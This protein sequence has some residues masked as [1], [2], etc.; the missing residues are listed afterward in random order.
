[1]IVIGMKKM[2][3]I[4]KMINYL[5]LG[6]LF[7]TH[8]VFLILPGKLVEPFICICR[9]VLY[10]GILTVLYVF[11]DENDCPVSKVRRDGLVVGVGTIIYVFCILMTGILVGFGKNI[12]ASSL[13]SIIISVWRYATVAVMSEVL[14]H[15]LIQNIPASPASQRVFFSVALTVVYAF[16]QLDALR[17]V[18][19][20][21]TNGI[22]DFF[23]TSVFP[24]LTLNAVLSYIAF[25]GSL[26]S[27][28]IIRWAYSLTPVLMPVLPNVSKPV[29]AT[30]SCAMLFITI[31]I[32]HRHASNN[33]NR[34]RRPKSLRD[35]YRKNT[36]FVL[37]VPLVLTSLLIAFAVRAFTFFPVVVLTESM[38][39]AIDR[40]SIVFVEKLR[41]EK[42]LKTVRQGDIIHYKKK[43]TE[44][45]HRVV[46]LRYSASGDMVCVTKGDANLVNDF[47]PVETKE[48]I[49]IVRAYI[50]YA[51]YPFTI[52]NKIINGRERT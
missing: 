39:G 43:N 23:F 40:G 33:G 29:W 22:I 1:M 41:P 17:N 44:I 19:S 30:I 48:I 25:I 36:V 2:K 20:F 10:S 34:P 49:G 15:K 32:Y 13:S 35:K 16:V 31:I 37:G 5:I 42:V 52:F 21:E 27:L 4:S 9:P 38:T 46:E 14:R 24:A 12:I 3:S 6:L 8:T 28:I 7:F 47:N 26:R 11:N 18:R 45:V 50:P 51:G